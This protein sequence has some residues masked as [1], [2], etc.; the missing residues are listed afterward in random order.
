[1]PSHYPNGFKEGLIVRGT[2]ILNT[3]AG[4]VWWVDSGVAGTSNQNDGK[5]PAT[6]FNTIDYAVGRCTASNG[7]I[8]MASPGHTETITAASG[9]ALDVAGITVVLMGSGSNRATINVTGAVTGAVN[10]TADNV[11]IVGGLM[12]GGV[13][14]IVQFIQVSGD[15]F[16]I[17]DSEMRDVTGET[18]TWIAFTQAATRGLVDGVFINGADAAGGAQAISIRG[19]ANHEI[20]N[21]KIDGNFS[22]SGIRNGGTAATEIYIHD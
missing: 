13:D 18:S 11:T 3:Y 7:D 10:V 6:A 14:V 16:K 20:R 15:D 4:N 21:S 2:P 19:G 22:I 17:I 8:I 1:M 5:T 9:L 12:T